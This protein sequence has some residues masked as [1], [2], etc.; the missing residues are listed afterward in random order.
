LLDYASEEIKNDLI[1]KMIA[2]EYCF[3]IGLSEPDSGSDLFAA[4]AARGKPV[5]VG[6]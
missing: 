3:C 5:R 1:P 6:Y 2:G 4:K